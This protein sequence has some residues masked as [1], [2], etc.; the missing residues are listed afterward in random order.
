MWTSRQHRL[1]VGLLTRYAEDKDRAG[2]DLEEAIDRC[3]TAIAAEAVSRADSGLSTTYAKALFMRFQSRRNEDDLTAATTTLTGLLDRLPE[4][5]LDRF[6]AL[7][8]LGTLQLTR[9]LLDKSRVDSAAPVSDQETR[10]A[11]ASWQQAARIPAAPAAERISLLATLGRYASGVG[12]WDEALDVC[13]A[14]AGLLPLL[15]WHGAA[16]RTQERMLLTATG[17]T[18]T[19]AACA[20]E[21]GQ[22]TEAVVLLEQTRSVLWAQHAALRTDLDALAERHP[23]LAGRLRQ[24]RAGLEAPIDPGELPDLAEPHSRRV[25]PAC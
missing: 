4:H 14:A 25:A 21:A 18:G 7:E 10:E 5:H 13:R 9:R 19:S 24:I 3:R 12:R 22:R 20:L 6:T 2:A 1:A 15:A 23:D 16:R 17:M 8:T 11:F